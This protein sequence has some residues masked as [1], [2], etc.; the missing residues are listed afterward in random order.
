MV[1][2][3]A[4]SSVA[5]TRDAYDHWRNVRTVRLGAGLA[6]YGLF[7]IVPLLVLA[8]ALVGALISP[9]DSVA[10]VRELIDGIPN[11]DPEAVAQ[12]IV[13]QVARSTSGLGLI[14][15][16]SALVAASFLFVALQDALNVIWEA[17]VRVGFRFSVRRRLLSG[18][19]ALLTALFFISSFLVQ[20][21][22][23]FAERLV[24]GDIPAFE[25]LAGVVATA[26]TWA[27]G[28]GTITLLFRLLPYA[29]VSWRSAL[30]GAAITAMLVAL[31]TSLIGAYISRFA[32]KSVSGAAGSIVAFLLW[33][34][35]EAQIVLAGAVLT[36]ILDDRRGAPTGDAA[37]PQG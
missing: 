27:L 14:G 37:G 6:Y 19:V 35:Y 36:K 12:D 10:F 29:A 21:V 22:V 4:E 34:Y 5:T 28:V 26:A 24:P 20:A 18:G 16:L 9:D 11:I 2:S 13:D 31:G 15:A 30:I 23:G 8:A 25:S 1:R 32:T 7:A 17:P 3:L 33:V